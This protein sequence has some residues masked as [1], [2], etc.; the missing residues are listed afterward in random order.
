MILFFLE[1]FTTLL[2][3]QCPIC[4]F[5]MGNHIDQVRCVTFVEKV[6]RWNS[7]SKNIYK[8]H[9]NFFG[10]LW[11]ISK[12][13]KAFTKS[14]PSNELHGLF[15][16]MSLFPI[17][18]LTIG[19]LIYRLVCYILWQIIDQN[20]GIYMV[21]LYVIWRKKLNSPKYITPWLALNRTPADQ[22]WTPLCHVT[23]DQITFITQCSHLI[24]DPFCSSIY[25]TLCSSC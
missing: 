15:C 21:G 16:F 12:Y 8:K 13:H 2:T 11:K 22:I 23:G 7:A 5:H 6:S 18:W 14:K 1:V 20:C 10:S 3:I 19:I 17:Y 25:H 24:T 4:L 9:L